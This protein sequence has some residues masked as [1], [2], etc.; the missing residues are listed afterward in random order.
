MKLNTFSTGDLKADEQCGLPVGVNSPRVAAS[1]QEL[2]SARLVST[3]FA[4][5]ADIP[6]EN[7][8]LLVMQWGQFLDH[9]LTHTPISR[10]K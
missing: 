1:G 5:E 8:T 3:Q 7:Y 10:G 2:P 6:Y 4:T 9:D